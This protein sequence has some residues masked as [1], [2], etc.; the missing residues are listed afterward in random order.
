MIGTRIEKLEEA[1]KLKTESLWERG[2]IIADL[3]NE[4]AAYRV[5]VDNLEL[6]V[7]Q[8][9]LFWVRFSLGATF[10]SSIITSII[11]ILTS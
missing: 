7:N 11:Y 3:E 4:N 2:G 5:T 1:L 9:R 10:V 8:V 6:K